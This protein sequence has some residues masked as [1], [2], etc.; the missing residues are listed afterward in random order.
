MNYRSLMALGL[1]SSL[2]FMPGCASL[3]NVL[4]SNT[5]IG[6]SIGATAGAIGG[7]VIG[8]PHHSVSGALIGT[9]S[10]AVLGALIG[11]LTEPK[12]DQRVEV[13]GLDRSSTDSD[14]PALTSPIVRKVWVGPKIEGEHYYEGHYMF[15]IER[16]S[17][18]K[19]Q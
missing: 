13:S 12:K 5:F 1:T 2:V 16:G 19:M 11:Y 14:S 17:I 18:W 4:K 9:A 10:G 3:G 7:T 6:G 15:V 8:S